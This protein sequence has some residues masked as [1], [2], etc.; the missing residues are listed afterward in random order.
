MELL[1]QLVT[2]GRIVDIMLGF[3]LLEILALLLL[4]RLTGKGIAP[5]PLITNIGA[6]GSLM[7]ALKTVLSGA[8]WTWTAGSLVL[9]LIFHMLDLSQRWN[10]GEA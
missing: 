8:A 7:L 10:K 3:V 6:G 4:F 5:V 2:S 1:E 9:A